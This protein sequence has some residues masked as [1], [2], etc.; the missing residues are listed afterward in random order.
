VARNEIGRDEIGWAIIRVGGVDML[1]G[2]F[3]YGMRRAQAGRERAAC[4]EYN[5]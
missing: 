4:D 3:C 2:D 1:R 5:S